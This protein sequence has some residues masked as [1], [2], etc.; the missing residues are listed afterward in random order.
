MIE[1]QCKIFKKGIQ[2]VHDWIDQTAAESTNKDEILKGLEEALDLI[3]GSLMRL[4]ADVEK[5]VAR[6]GG[7]FRGM[8]VTMAGRWVI[9]RYVFNESA[10]KKHLMQLQ[11][12]A[13]LLHLTLSVSQ[14]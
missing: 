2:H 1:A 10:M 5:V 13:A 8:G 9:A 12:C 4:N 7:A 3:Q 14:L 11:E 6:A